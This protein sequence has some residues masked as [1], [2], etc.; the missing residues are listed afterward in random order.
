[1]RC[2]GCGGEF[3]RREGYAVQNPLTEVTWGRYDCKAGCGEYL[4]HRT[5]VKNVDE[6][7]MERVCRSVQ[8][9]SGESRSPH[10]AE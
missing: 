10:E 3:T 7:E 1:M 2:P 9:G 4:I 6:I 8:S 5:R